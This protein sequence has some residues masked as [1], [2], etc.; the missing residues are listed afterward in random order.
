MGGNGQTICPGPCRKANISKNKPLHR[1]RCLVWIHA[2]DSRTERVDAR[3]QFGQGF[4][5]GQTGCHV[6][7]QRLAHICCSSPNLLS[8]FGSKV[9][10]FPSAQRTPK[11]AVLDRAQQVSVRYPT[12]TQLKLTDI[13]GF[14]GQ[15][16]FARAGQ[17]ISPSGEPY[18][19]AAVANV[20]A[21]R[22]IAG[23]CLTASG[24]QAASEGHGRVLAVV[25][26]FYAQ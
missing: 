3:G 9:A 8:Q 18:G 11:I 22:H 21:Q 6:D 25:K 26:A 4:A 20:A 17:D 5:H 16:G 2:G 13:H 24:R 23:Q 14:Y 1:G 12:Q 7:I 19:G 15:R 10:I